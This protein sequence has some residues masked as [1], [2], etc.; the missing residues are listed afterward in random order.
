ML[1][2]SWIVSKSVEWDPWI[3]SKSEIWLMNGIKN[4]LKVEINWKIQLIPNAHL[5]AL[6]ENLSLWCARV[7]T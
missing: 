7:E 2:N 5:V 6:R 3:V 1:K 4:K